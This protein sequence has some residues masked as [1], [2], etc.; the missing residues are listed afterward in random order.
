[1][2]E[3]GVEFLLMGSKISESLTMG[4]EE[5][6]QKS[7]KSIVHYHEV[8]NCMLFPGSNKQQESIPVA[9]S[10]VSTCEKPVEEARTDRLFLDPTWKK[11]SYYLE[12]IY[13]HT[14]KITLSLPLI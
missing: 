2:Q 13:F 1:M 7:L 6:R 3:H 10:P 5:L 8:S 14:G 9:E 11:S 12:D 4:L